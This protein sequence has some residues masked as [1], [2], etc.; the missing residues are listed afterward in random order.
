MCSKNR[1]GPVRASKSTF[2]IVQAKKRRFMDKAG[3][4][5]ECLSCDVNIFEKSHKLNVIE[6]VA[7]KYLKIRLLTYARHHSLEIIN[8]PTKRKI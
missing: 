1:G 7:N 6:L 5:K 3:I 8:P 4:F 2:D